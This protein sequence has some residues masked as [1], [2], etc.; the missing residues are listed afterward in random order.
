MDLYVGVLL[1]GLGQLRLLP[2]MVV[3]ILLAQALLFPHLRKQLGTRLLYRLQLPQSFMVLTT[4]MLIY[5]FKI[6]QVGLLKKDIFRL[7][8]L[9]QKHFLWDI[10]C[11]RLQDGMIR[12]FTQIQPIHFLWNK[13]KRF[14]IPLD[15]P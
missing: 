2:M 5:L 3:S 4:E 9:F 7:S 14:S 13:F 10:P 11:R 15:K 1:M 12:F 6:D 8:R